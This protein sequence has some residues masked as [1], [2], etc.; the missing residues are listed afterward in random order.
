MPFWHFH[1]SITSLI[2]TKEVPNFL[3][4]PLNL[5]K[6]L[7]EACQRILVSKRKETLN[8]ISNVYHLRNHVLKLPFCP[9]T[10]NVTHVS[11]SER[12][13]PVYWLARGV[14]FL[15][16][17][18]NCEFWTIILRSCSVFEFIMHKWMWHLLIFAMAMNFSVRSNRRAQVLFHTFGLSCIGGA[19]FLQLLVFTD[20]LQHGYFTAVENN[21]AILFS[22][23]LLTGFSALYFAYMYQRFIRSVR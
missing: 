7:A 3:E 5:M 20:I 23:I 2:A 15:I 12:N 8:K 22:E 18:L 17:D 4:P 9:F 16:I 10:L 1:Q 21:P 11:S 13:G 6:D 19:I 14:W